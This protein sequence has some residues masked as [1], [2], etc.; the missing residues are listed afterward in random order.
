[1]IKSIPKKKICNKCK[2]NKLLGQFHLSSSGKYGRTTFCKS[3]RSNYQKANRHVA[4]KNERKR[5]QKIAELIIT[6]KDVPCKDCG[7]K[8]PYYV[9]DFDHKQD[10]IFGIAKARG[11]TFNLERI[12]AEAKKCDVVCSNCHRERTHQRKQNGS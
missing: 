8:Y 11:C 2:K 7:I 6:L 10:K 3:C 9:M 5:R 4:L 1:M 12:K